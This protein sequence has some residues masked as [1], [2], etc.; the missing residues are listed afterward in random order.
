MSVEWMDNT[1]GYQCQQC[2]EVF[3]PW[4]YGWPPDCCTVK[5]SIHLHLIDPPEPAPAEPGPPSDAEVIGAF[6]QGVR[7]AC[8]YYT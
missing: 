1:V 2:S 3:G 6:I 8:R 7:E 5:E 4:D